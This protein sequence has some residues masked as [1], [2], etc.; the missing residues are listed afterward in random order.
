MTGVAV[1]FI[2][3]IFLGISLIVDKI[4]FGDHG[5]LRVFPYVFWIAIMSCFGFI[6]FFF[7]FTMP[8]IKVIGLVFLAALSFLLMLLCYYE[9]LTGRG[10]RG[11]SRSGWFCPACHV[12][13]R[14]LLCYEQAEYF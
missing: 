8:G 3:Q 5:T 7:G 1:A 14:Q 2:A 12:Y 10:V 4:F 9:V 13:Y 6:F 11:C